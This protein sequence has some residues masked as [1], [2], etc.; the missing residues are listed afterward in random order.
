MFYACGRWGKGGDSGVIS[1][2]VTRISHWNLLCVYSNQI[3]ATV[4]NEQKDYIA[5]DLHFI[6]SKH[7]PELYFSNISVR[8][9]HSYKWPNINDRWT[10]KTRNWTCACLSDL[11]CF[12]LMWWSWA[13]AVC[14]FALRQAVVVVWWAQ[15]PHPYSNQAVSGA[16]YEN[17][18][19]I[20]GPK[21]NP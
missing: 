6:S 15:G 2:T 11:L 19:Q 16:L 13:H 4:F 10:R 1:T 17:Q 20:A 12:I 18:L 3:R 14:A 5:R 9:K 21:A 7:P 8:I